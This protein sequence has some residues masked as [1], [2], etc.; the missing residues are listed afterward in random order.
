VTPSTSDAGT[1]YRGDMERVIVERAVE[2]AGVVLR[3]DGADLLLVEFDA[4][5]PMV[6]VAVDLDGAECPECVIPPEL[7]AD[8]IGDAVRR[9]VDG[10]IEVIVDDPRAGQP[11][12]EPATH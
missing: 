11:E 1:E 8:I 6:R 5:V 9:G 7:L 4:A 3:A 12:S 2:D 10:D